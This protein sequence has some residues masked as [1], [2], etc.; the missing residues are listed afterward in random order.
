[1][2]KILLD[3][4][5]SS[6]TYDEVNYTTFIV[7]NGRVLK[8]YKGGEYRFSQI[9]GV[10]IIKNNKQVSSGGHALLGAVL[11]G[12]P[13]AVAGSM[14]GRKTEE[15]LH[16][17]HLRI[18][19]RNADKEFVD[20]RIFQKDNHFMWRNALQE[21]EQNGMKVYFIITDYLERTNR[22]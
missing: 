22:V 21:E 7:D 4:G 5:S 6:F 15:V 18:Y 13:G 8:R 17:I 1:M 10:D 20:L 11:F 14:I 12:T 9:R 16:T 3:G 19:L 2:L